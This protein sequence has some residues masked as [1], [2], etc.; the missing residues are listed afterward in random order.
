[1]VLTQSLIKALEEI[2]QN[3]VKAPPKEKES[4][5]SSFFS[6]KQTDSQPI[7]HRPEGNLFGKF[8]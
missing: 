3:Q 5:F 1:M 7:H 4:F 2:K 8:D 6:K